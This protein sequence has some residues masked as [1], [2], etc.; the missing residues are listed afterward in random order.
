[1]DNPVTPQQVWDTWSAYLI[2]YFRKCEE[3]S[4]DA[5]IKEIII[6]YAS[7]ESIPFQK[8]LADYIK[9]Q[10]VSIV[11]NSE[12]MET[13]TCSFQ[14]IKLIVI[15]RAVDSQIAETNTDCK[16]KKIT[17]N[18][19]QTSVYREYTENQNYLIYSDGSVY[20]RYSN[21]FLSPSISSG[22]HTVGL[23]IGSKKKME[24]IHRLVALYFVTNLDPTKCTTVNHKDSNKLNNNYLNLEWV[25]PQYNA[26]HA[27]NKISYTAGHTSCVYQLDIEGN[28][29]NTFDSIVEAAK[30]TGISQ[31]MISHCCGGRTNK[32]TDNNGIEYRWQF[33][34]ESKLDKVPIDAKPIP[35][36]DNYL[37][38][39]DGKVYSLRKGGYLIQ[40]VTPDGYMKV[41]LKTPTRKDN[42]MVHR[43]VAD[44]YLPKD[45]SR[46]IVNHKNSNRQD[47][48]VSN[49]EYVTTRENSIHSYKTGNSAKFKKAV[50]MIDPIKKTVL[51]TFTSIAE[52][53]E[54]TKIDKMSISQCCNK[55]YRL[56]GGYLWQFEDE[57]AIREITPKSTSACCIEQLNNITGEIVA[58]FASMTQAAQ[59]INGD[60]RRISDV[61]SGKLPEYKGWMWRKA[62]KEPLTSS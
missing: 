14:R 61:C 1:M 54:T 32:S 40:N 20:S 57:V 24:R 9:L 29:V 41:C 35:D 28:I 47:N 15:P 52:A 50:K 53:S 26:T 3:K 7:D 10:V 2:P 17:T 37:I 13:I 62:I 43:L 46:Q 4:I 49:L 22:Y 58:S 8:Q 51:A 16:D 34:E 31:S 60:I 44:A 23:Q 6:K 12:P 59:S 18:I 33:V 5:V 21:L 39:N 48:H 55:R 30:H 36:F 19:T 38:T 11:Y 56:G 42:F 25:T 27:V 45:D